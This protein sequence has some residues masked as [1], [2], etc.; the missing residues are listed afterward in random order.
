MFIPNIK[1]IIPLLLG[2]LI[3]SCGKP[4]EE[5]PTIVRITTLTPPVSSEGS[6]FQDLEGNPV[7][8]SDYMGKRVVL[9]YW[10]TWCAPCIREIPALNRAAE[11]LDDEEFVFLL[12]SDES[13]EEIIEFV[14]DHE[15]EGN[16]LKLNSFFASFGVE[17][18]PS[19]MLFDIDGKI[20][21][22]WLGEYEWDSPLLLAELR[23]SE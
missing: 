3:T 7:E 15:F 17:A 4:P 20:I 10:A 2:T 21:N 18:V 19:T 9:N 8:I 12:A 23:E 13:P 1:I 11:I 22:T 6:T 14:A 5:A 16:F